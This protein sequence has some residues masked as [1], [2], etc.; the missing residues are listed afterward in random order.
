MTMIGSEGKTMKRLV[1]GV[2]VA[3]LLIFYT[4][5]FAADGVGKA[6][7]SDDLGFKLGI[8]HLHPELV[9]STQ[10]DTNVQNAHDNEIADMVFNVRGGI[11]MDIPAKTVGF[12]L[13]GFV[14]Y[15]KYFGIDNDSSTKLDSLDVKGRLSLSVLKDAII[16]I[17]MN[18]SIVRSSVPE[19]ITVY[20]VQDRIFNDAF[21]RFV[22]QP[23]GQSG[24]LKVMLGYRNGFNH[25]DKDSYR[26]NNYLKHTGELGLQWKFFP[27]T[28]LFFSGSFGYQDYYEFRADP[29]AGQEKSP[30]AMPLQL[31][32]GVA[33]R[34]TSFMLIK[35]SVGYVNSLSD[36]LEGYNSA[37]ATAEATFQPLENVGI[38]LGY[39]RANNVVNIHGSMAA[40]KAYLELKAWTINDRLRFSVPCSYQYMQYGNAPD[41][42]TIVDL[43]GKGRNDHVIRVEP[44]VAFYATP[45]FGISVQYTFMMRDS[46]LEFA[47]TSGNTVNYDFIKHQAMLGLTFRY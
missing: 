30:N 44:E 33:G 10:Y 6:N 9:L 36:E 18:D 13:E 26:N 31:S 37:N 24:T 35:L 4:I 12:T 43:R 41:D 40:N 19:G 29:T 23:N 2:V 7:T 32:V 34:V 39:N 22:V 25:Y 42:T 47:D 17:Q 1:Q 11:A 21:V 3:V 38:T 5:G 46:D 27:K 15:S 8:V 20:D 28:S 45:W 14:G 16:N